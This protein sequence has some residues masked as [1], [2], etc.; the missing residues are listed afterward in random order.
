MIEL[1]GLS[2]S[3]GKKKAIDGLSLTL[4]PGEVFGLL[5]P[6][7]AGKSTTIKMITGILKPDSGTVTLDGKDI[8]KE[9]EE[10]KRTFGFVPDTPDLF[11][12]MKGGEYLAFLASLYPGSK[13]EKKEKAL[14]LARAFRI[15]EAL[16][17]PIGSYSHGM[18]QKIL[19]VGSL[20]NDPS[21]W[22]LDEPMT[23]LDPESAFLVKE[24]MKEFSQEGKTVLFS[25]HVLD[26]AEKVCDRV[27]ILSKGKL[28]FAGTLEELKK[29]ENEKEE[30]L[31]QLFLELTER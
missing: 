30:G 14:A 19:I 10:A 20:L 23:G 25:T 18:R 13:E 5:G 22:I 8:V 27:G 2:K 21:N 31:E 9:P 4:G 17:D 7:G 3:Y 29:A 16:K 1:S 15:E 6:N 28:L 24:K 26:V 11:L 12:G